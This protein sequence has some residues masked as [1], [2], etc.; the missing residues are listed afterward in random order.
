MAIDGETAMDTIERRD[1]L[2]HINL[3]LSL[4]QDSQASTSASEMDAMLS[5]DD[6]LRD[7]S[8]KQR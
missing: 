3:C 8:E 4:E 7:V 1:S 6:T 5:Y 2:T